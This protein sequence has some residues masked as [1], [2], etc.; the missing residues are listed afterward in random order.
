MTRPDATA[1]TDHFRDELALLER[2]RSLADTECGVIREPQA[3]VFPPGHHRQIYGYSVATG[4]PSSLYPGIV[5]VPGDL[6]GHGTSRDEVTARIRAS[7][8]A[9][10][11]YCSVMC[12]A[13][14]ILHATANELGDDALDPGRLPQCSARERQRASAA[15]QLAVPDAGAVERWVEGF[16]LTRG[17]Q[18]WLP[19]T[20]VYMGLPE[21]L[22]SQL[23]FPEST[24]FAAGS[25]YDGAILAALCEVIERDSLTLWWLHKLPM[26]QILADD[27]PDPLATLLDQ[28][29]QAGIRTHL[30]DLTSDLGV[31]VVGAVQTSTQGSPRAVAMGACRPSGTAAALRVIEEVASLRVALAW[32]SGSV[33]REVVQSGTPLPPAQFGL[34]YAGD[35]GPGRFSFATRDA[36][37]RPS[38]PAPVEGPDPLSV[39]ISLL[40]NHGMEVFAVDVTLPEVRDVG[41]VVVRVVVP[42]LMR[43]SFSHSIR[44]L[45]HPRLYEAPEMMGFGRRTE[46][47]ITDDPIPFA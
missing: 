15:C 34:L 6:T 21:P 23:M 38:F 40:G 35:D 33:S 22:S 44:Y 37:K 45:A 2:L 25:G 10:E 5:S 36:P 3:L 19:L 20:A 42:E 12:P 30:F 27:W 7:C 16:S 11:R 28:A 47:M 13:S 18:A 46:D 1:F 41:L 17:K 31:P 26:P 9:L 39:I 43:L 32:T 14:R 8:E 29:M 4:R 24:G